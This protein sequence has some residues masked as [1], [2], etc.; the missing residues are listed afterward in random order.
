MTSDDACEASEQLIVL[1]NIDDKSDLVI[2]SVACCHSVKLCAL[3]AQAFRPQQW[4]NVFRQ[5]VSIL[6]HEAKPVLGLF[7]LHLNTIH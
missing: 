1:T 5:V 7:C 4:H 2:S 6:D 3:A